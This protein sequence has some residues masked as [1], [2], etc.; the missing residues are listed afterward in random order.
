MHG[1]VR[2]WRRVGRVRVGRAGAGVWK[3]VHGSSHSSGCFAAQLPRS[4]AIALQLNQAQCLSRL[5]SVPS[6]VRSMHF[7]P[8]KHQGALF[9]REAGS[10]S[11]VHAVRI[12]STEVDTRATT[13]SKRASHAATESSCSSPS[14]IAPRPCAPMHTPTL[15]EAAY[16]GHQFAKEWL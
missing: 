14:Y 7:V 2:T 4:S 13:D 3:P 6:L 16:L 15:T 5:L 9:A 12:A 10:A 8:I 11:G 1:R